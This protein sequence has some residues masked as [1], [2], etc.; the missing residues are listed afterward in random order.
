M[1][2]APAKS[3][4]TRQSALPGLVIFD[5]DGVLVDS[6]PLSLETLSKTFADFGVILSPDEVGA[7]LLGKSIKQTAAEISQLTGN[8]VTVDLV[9][10]RWYGRLFDRFRQELKPVA[11]MEALLDHLTTLGIPFCIA[12]GA[13]MERLQVALDVTGLASRFTGKVFSADSVANGK[14][15]PDIFLKAARDL[16]VPPADCLVIEDAPAGTQGAIAAGMRVLGFVG[17]SHLEGQRTE[18]GKHLSAL[19]AEAVFETAEAL[20]DYLKA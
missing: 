20:T 13:S 8:P 10:Q 14:P 11:G 19:K 12:S 18:H 6:E 1:K 15:A 17:G 2:D 16:S 7:R 4:E 9:A 3:R 5:F